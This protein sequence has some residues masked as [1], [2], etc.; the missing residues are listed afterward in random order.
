MAQYNPQAQQGGGGRGG[1]GRGYQGRGGGGPQHQGRPVGAWQTSAPTSSLQQAAYGRQ[2]Q[3]GGYHHH[4]QHHHNQQ[5]Y[6]QHHHHNQHLPN[7]VPPHG[8]P[9]GP[10]AGVHVAPPHHQQHHYNPYA[11]QGSYRGGQPQPGGWQ[12]AAYPQGG[13]YYPPATAH[14]PA[15]AAA[16]PV[17]QPPKPREKKPLLITD[18]HGNVPDWSKKGTKSS[19][20]AAV[21]A[22]RGETDEKRS[23]AGSKL[24]EAALAAL[25]Q[26]DE[27]DKPKETPKDETGDSPKPTEETPEPKEEPP[28]EEKAAPAPTPP[29][30]PPAKPVEE[31]PKKPEEKAAPAPAPAPEKEPEPAPEPPKPVEEPPKPASEPP[32]ATPEP[33][34][35]VETPAPEPPAK[36]EKKEEPPKPATKTLAELAAAAPPPSAKPLSA[37]AAVKSGNGSSLAAA[38]TKKPNMAAVAAA[39]A[40][41]PAKVGLRPGGKTRSTPA[42]SGKG[43]IVFDKKSLM[44]YKSCE[45]CL[46][47]PES[48]PDMTIV[49]GPAKPQG[50]GGGG[51][52]GNNRNRD[53]GGGRRD[54]DRG[55]QQPRRRGS[56]QGNNNNNDNWTRG[57]EPP[58]NKNSRN[59][60]RRG[61]QGNQPPLYDG[62]VAPLVKSANGWKPTKDNSP[63]AAA[64]KQV[65]SI[66]NKMT[67][68]KFDR[69]S[70]QMIEIQVLSYDML[71]MMLHNVYEKAIDEPS[72]GEMY[73]ELCVKMSKGATQANNDFVKLIESDEEPPTEGD[74]APASQQS[75]SSSHIVYRWSNDVSTTDD[76]VVGPFPNA[77]ACVNAALEGSGEPQKRGE[78]VLELVKL[79]IK[80][81]VF[82]KV[83]KKKD[84]SPSDGDIF[85]TVYFNV[86]EAEECGQ[87]LSE[88]FLSE[89]ECISNAKKFN[90]FKRSLLNK[91]EDEFK[92]KEIFADWEKEKKEYEEKKSTFTP[93]QQAEKEEDFEFRRLKIKKQKLGNAKFIGQLYKAGLLKEKIV[94][95]C[96]SDLLKLEELTEVR[97]KNPEY[98]DSCDYQI[99]LED[100]E[101]ICSLFSTV[102]NTIDHKTA[103]DFMKVCFNKIYKLS[104]DQKNLPARSRFMYKDLIELRENRWVPRRDE[105][106]AKS[107]EEI[108]KDF[109]REEKKQAQQSQQGYRNDRNDNRRGSQQTGGYDNRRGGNYGG[110]GGGGGGGGRNRPSAKPAQE[111]DDDG[112]TVIGRGGNKGHFQS[113]GGGGGGGGGRGNS[114]PKQ[115][116]MPKSG[117]K[118]NFS[119]LNNE[120]R[121]KSPQQGRRS[122]SPTGAPSTPAPAALSPEKLERRIKS[123]RSEFM[124]DGNID[125]LLL[126]MDELSGTPDAGQTLVLK[127]ADSLLECKEAERKAITDTIRILYE[128]KKLSKDDI[129]NGLVDCI[130]FIDSMVCD[131]PKVFEYVADLL[132]ALFKVNAVDVQWLCDSLEKTKVDPDTPA[133]E[134]L[135]R[136]TITSVRSQDGPDAAKDIFG[137]SSSA[138]N[139]LLGADKWNAISKDL[140]G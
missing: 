2:Q 46:Q 122:K 78:M 70:T 18:K 1:G 113:G 117:S 118:S 40:P 80:Q 133:P 77:D 95:F 103:A 12:Q 94:R 14:P 26:T 83:M 132:S 17:V 63:L 27:A 34:K 25:N 13:V 68:E 86:D 99:D 28:K 22:E 121:S 32:K 42:P 119:S 66:L 82:V 23:D 43:R 73:A 111:T 139:S 71:T 136:A 41:S 98:K 33:P 20:R 106:K 85:Y 93:A 84:A 112:F 11:H 4:N 24:K 51:G 44:K 67:K 79:I 124:Q 137:K 101:A 109:E 105:G 54:W 108:R 39:P 88:I 72:F 135:T 10:Y 29:P 53:G 128:K 123:M 120:N 55:Q 7:A 74:A 58:R 21:A 126:S 64:E 127:S 30:A 134:K 115:Q 59:N 61:S 96:V 87:Q 76:E 75:Q 130:E 50:G 52:G 57:N 6:S 81:G 65:K 129:R 100:H 3:Q 91:C 138:M 45:S 56:Q 110:R 31:P 47:R 131:C 9:P 49:K 92:K 19:L 97:S 35:P 102:G 114:Q 8:G 36:E 140:L 5:N 69:L 125:E 104:V 48:L 90:S 116:S 16:A 15:A 38:A 62:P 107:L 60:N 37:A 89:V